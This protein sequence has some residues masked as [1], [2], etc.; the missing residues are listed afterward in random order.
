[1]FYWQKIKQNSRAQLGNL[2]EAD[3]KFPLT[4]CEDQFPLARTEAKIDQQYISLTHSL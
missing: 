1:M 3:L 2:A 4:L